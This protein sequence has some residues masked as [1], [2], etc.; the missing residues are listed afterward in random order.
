MMSKVI[1]GI[2]LPNRNRSAPEFQK[3][4]SAYGCSIITR[5][6]LHQASAEFCSEQGLILLEFVDGGD[7]DAEKLEKALNEIDGIVVKK[8]IF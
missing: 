6:G 2:Q 1:M 5:I 8:M 4:L 3:I 7:K